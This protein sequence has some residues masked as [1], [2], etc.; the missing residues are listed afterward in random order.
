[1][2]DDADEDHTSGWGGDKV[3][4]SDFG[5]Y[6]VR[7]LGSGI[8][9]QEGGVFFWTARHRYRFPRRLYHLFVLVGIP[10]TTRYLR[11]KFW[12]RESLA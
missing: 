3:D 12:T 7:M 4:P 2:T 5:G 8:E 9:Y 1:M 11:S 6:A 10:A